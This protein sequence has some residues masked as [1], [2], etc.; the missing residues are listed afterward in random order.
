[1]AAR[2]RVRVRGGGGG[3]G[4]RWWWRC[5]AKDK[6]RTRAARVRG[7]PYNIYNNV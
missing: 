5:P 1:M 7:G 2:V 4:E 6:G 3:P